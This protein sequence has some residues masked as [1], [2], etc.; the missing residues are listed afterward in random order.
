[1][2]RRSVSNRGEARAQD[3]ARALICD[4]VLPR[5]LRAVADAE[6]E[7]TSVLAAI[8]RRVDAARRADGDTTDAVATLSFV[9][10]I[11][12]AAVSDERRRRMSEL[13]TDGTP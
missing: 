11:V 4:D 10:Q 2:P 6:L 1:M 5:L 9:R 3:A 7:A 8:R 12:E 13:G